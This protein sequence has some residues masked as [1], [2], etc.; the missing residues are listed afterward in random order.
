MKFPRKDSAAN[1]V[2]GVIWFA[3]VCVSVVTGIVGALK[4]IALVFGRSIWMDWSGFV[5]LFLGWAGWEALNRF[6]EWYNPSDRQA[7]E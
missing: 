4:I 3:L 1:Q 5:L 6:V 2:V 7:D